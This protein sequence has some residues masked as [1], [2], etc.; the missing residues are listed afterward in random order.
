MLQ[1]GPSHPD[2]QLLQ[3]GFCGELA[4]KAQKHPDEVEHSEGLQAG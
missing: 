1:Y 3:G 2:E 4:S